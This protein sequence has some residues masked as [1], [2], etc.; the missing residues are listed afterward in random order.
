MSDL[1]RMRKQ[2]YYR[3]WLRN[4]KTDEEVYLDAHSL[5][6]ALSRLHW[7]RAITKVCQIYQRTGKPSE[8]VLR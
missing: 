3:Y 7:E 1:D 8:L 5:K 4:I 6:E 2:H